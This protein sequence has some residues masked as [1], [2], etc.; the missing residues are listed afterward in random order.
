M[1]P[2]SKDKEPRKNLK[3]ETIQVGKRLRIRDMK[4]V[5]M[6][7]VPGQE[8]AWATITEQVVTQGMP[9]EEALALQAL[10]PQ[11]TAHS[12]VAAQATSL[13][14]QAAGKP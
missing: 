3:P 7:L 14:V 4:R 11:L 1:I 10:I 6:P 5:M 13:L 12:E 2:V 8:I 9:G